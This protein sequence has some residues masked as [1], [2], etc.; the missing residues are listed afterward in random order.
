MNHDQAFLNLYF[1]LIEN[2]VTIFDISKGTTRPSN[3]ELFKRYGLGCHY[4]SVIINF[5]S[6]SGIGNWISELHLTK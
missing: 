4:S 5:T 6:G 2:G 3:F 1:E